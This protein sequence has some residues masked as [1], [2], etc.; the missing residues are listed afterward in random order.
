MPEVNTS[1]YED[2][3][4]KQEYFLES[5]F[6]NNDSLKT[7]TIRYSFSPNPELYKKY[8]EVFDAKGIPVKWYI[9]K[10]NGNFWETYLSCQTDTFYNAADKSTE[11][12][13]T[14]IDLNQ[15]INYSLKTIFYFD[16]ERKVQSFVNYVKNASNS[17]S[18]SD[19]FADIKWF[20]YFPVFYINQLNYQ[21]WIYKGA[22]HYKAF[23]WNIS[24]S[25]WNSAVLF[26]K[27]FNKDT[28]VSTE[29]KVYTGNP[30]SKD[31]SRTLYSYY[32][33]GYQKI[34]QNQI[35]KDDQWKT[36]YSSFTRNTYDA[37]GD[38]V[39]SSQIIEQEGDYQPSE[40]F[41]IY[42]RYTGGKAYRR[43]A[44]NYEYKVYP[45]PTEDVLNISVPDAD[46][47]SFK[48][49]IYNTIGQQIMQLNQNLRDFKISLKDF[50]AGMY[51]LAFESSS[52]L[53][54]I[55]IIKAQGKIY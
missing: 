25:N 18:R 45:N 15:N 23:Y 42:Y 10:W 40:Q 1:F 43:K 51:F 29:Y 35:W 41:R 28:S 46:S 50:P 48:I 13:Q 8:N 49:S 14:Y 54:I 26:N 47:A 4:R 24:D 30:D 33:D 27:E 38:I 44:P 12:I 17:W 7:V 55:K 20:N 31:S 3:N 19:S 6:F 37:D 53:K 9:E 11:V 21:N 39:F 34:I 16:T 22:T 52:G 2:K 5:N 36:T 32:P